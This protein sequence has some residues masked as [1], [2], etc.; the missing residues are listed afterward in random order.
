MRLARTR[1]KPARARRALARGLSSALRGGSCFEN[2]ARSHFHHGKNRVL[3]EGLYEPT[4]IT[5]PD[6]D[7]SPDGARFLMLKPI[8]SAEAAPTQ[9]NVAGELI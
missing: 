6:Y 8:E 5:L 3:F 4:P 2:S 9:I 1:L 7:V